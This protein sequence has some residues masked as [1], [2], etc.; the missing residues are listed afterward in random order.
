MWSFW[1]RLRHKMVFT[2][3]PIAVNV[4]MIMQ[5]PPQCNEYRDIQSYRTLNRETFRQLFAVYKG[6]GLCYWYHVIVWSCL[7]V[8]KAL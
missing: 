5:M 6:S 2:K 4:Q 1:Q 3:T 7:F 8:D